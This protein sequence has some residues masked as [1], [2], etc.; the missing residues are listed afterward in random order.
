MRASVL[1]NETNM[2]AS[3]RSKHTT[4]SFVTWPRLLETAH[5]FQS[6]AAQAGSADCDILRLIHPRPPS[7]AGIV[8]PKTSNFHLWFAH[9]KGGNLLAA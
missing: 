5:A 1:L 4:E 7:A 3:K 6:E 9:G 2:R 8:Q